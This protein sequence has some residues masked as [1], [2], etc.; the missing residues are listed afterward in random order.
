V[1]TN[2]ILFGT[3]IAAQNRGLEERMLSIEHIAIALLAPIAAA[4]GWLVATRARRGRTTWAGAGAALSAAVFAIA[5]AGVLTGASTALRVFLI[6]VSA[7]TRGRTV[8]LTAQVRAAA[9]KLDPADQVAIVALGRNAAIMLPPMPVSQLPAALPPPTGV[10][11]DGTNYDEALRLADGLFGPGLS[12][13]IVLITDGRDNAPQQPT[14]VRRAVHSFTLAATPEKD[15]W[16]NTVSAPVFA[17][18]G[19]NVPF[20]VHVG[21]SAPI[22]GK[23]ILLL[24]GREL[25][26]PESLDIVERRTVLAHSVTLKQPGLYTLTARLQCDDDATS[27]NNEASATVRVR[28]RLRVAYLSDH[29]APA[30]ASILAADP[31]I[32]L[33]RRRPDALP[34]TNAS[35]L[36]TDVVVLDNVSK[37]K[38]GLARM[39]WLRRFVAD[40][41]GGLLVAGGP[42]SFGPGGYANTPLA[43]ILPVD[44]DPERRAA[45]PSSVVVVVD[46][47]GSMAEAIGGRR[48]IEFVREAV[49]RAGAEF[50]A[51]RGDRSDELS[52]VAFNQKPEV[53]LVAG[54]VGAPAGAAALRGAVA[55]IFPL[56]Q[57]DIEPALAAAIELVRTSPLKRHIILVS[58]GRSRSALDGARIARSLGA[59]AIVL[60]VLATAP[61]AADPSTMNVGLKALKAAALKT[62]GRYVPLSD[63][64]DL[65]A[66]MARSSRAIAGSLVRKAKDGEAFDV[67]VS[68]APSPVTVAAPK[69]I[70]GYVLT[71]ARPEAT[72][73]ATVDGAPLLAVWRQG[74]GRVGACTTSL[75]EWATDWP[76][77]AP[78]LFP[79][80][81]KWAGAGGRAQDV[82]V[83]VKPMAR[84]LDIAVQVAKPLDESEPTATVFT[85]GGKSITVPLRRIGRLR[86]EA[87]AAADERGTYLVTVSGRK[88][89]TVLGEGHATLGYSAEW[90]PG[91]DASAARRLS[92]LTGGTVLQSLSDLPPLARGGGR[93]GAR[94]GSSG[95]R[96]D[97]SWAVLL[98]AAAVF[99]FSTLRS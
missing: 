78:K 24:N 16:V 80:L 84:R 40:A 82:T 95:A 99:L 53:M 49:L 10:D 83:W 65:P 98:L 70:Q 21:A 19:Q 32:T 63:I 87:T 38:L 23:L 48:K 3:G 9:A 66:A 20:E 33:V 67:A 29:R 51:R 79:D 50:G 58:D 88:T 64:A 47:S 39:A 93:S 57:T 81:V 91:G 69:Q 2:S 60:S 11:Q 96:R 5:L 27:E 71:G 13:D 25:A 30:L 41:G 86:Y 34:A 54:K 45:K 42:D 73:L 22:S 31:A 17:P 59:H 12:G 89:G 35:M 36:G 43:G 92:H 7:S 62:K 85:P 44:P 90:M 18:A 55:K 56:G 4:A 75:D 76:T 68:K 1:I 46:R 61:D 97:I 15:A 72:P 37:N 8:E 28:G 74:L 26:R 94:R 6:D 52:I 14:S 77:L